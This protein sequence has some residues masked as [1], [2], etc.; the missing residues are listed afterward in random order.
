M[1]SD[2]LLGDRKAF[3]WRSSLVVIALDL[4]LDGREY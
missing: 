4:P 3:W 2:S 1:L